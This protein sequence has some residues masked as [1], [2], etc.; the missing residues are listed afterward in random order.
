MASKDFQ[1][2][3]SDSKT[4]E[5]MAVGRHL[6]AVVRGEAAW[7]LRQAGAGDV[8][9]STAREIADLWQGL[10]ADRS[11]LRCNLDG[12]A[13]VAEHADYAD[14]AERYDALLRELLEDGRPRSSR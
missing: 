4:Y 14:L 3:R 1:S 8:V 2:S 10:I 13:W 7:V 6:T 11:R 9:G 12:R 5:V